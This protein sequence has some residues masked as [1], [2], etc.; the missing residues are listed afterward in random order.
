MVRF[1]VALLEE[2]GG[3]YNEG[4][5]SVWA[6]R[7]DA[8]VLLND[9]LLFSGERVQGHRL[10]LVIALDTPH[11]GFWPSGIDCWLLD[12]DRTLEKRRFGCEP[13]KEALEQAVD[14]AVEWA[15]G[16][17]LKLE[18]EIRRV[19]VAAP[20]RILLE[21]RPEDAGAEMMLAAE[22]D[23]TL[24]WSE[25]LRVKAATH[26]RRAKRSL[27]KIRGSLSSEGDSPI[28]WVTLAEMADREELVARVRRGQLAKAVGLTA[29][30]DASL[31]EFLLK[32]AA[33]LVWPRV[34]TATDV[35]TRAL[36]E[37]WA[38]LPE[39]LSLAYR[40]SQEEN[41]VLPLGELRAIWDDGEWLDFCVGCVGG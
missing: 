10:R 17:A 7:I 29:R 25:R 33:I 23:V 31:L 38:A 35:H 15:E 5:L 27:S 19:D 1:V 3:E 34:E 20:A 36:E 24:H 13:T 14:S 4:A 28:N 40:K 22:Y 16:E 2:V 41:E 8:E 11:S 26:L 9:E 21:W 18:L 32:S 39:A 12:R 30:P 37:E 6:R